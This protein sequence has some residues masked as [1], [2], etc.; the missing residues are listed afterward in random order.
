MNS[1]AWELWEGVARNALEEARATP[2]VSAFWLARAHGFEVRPWASA[3][4]R[5]DERE[6]VIYVTPRARPQRRHGLVAHELG[7]HLLRLEHRLEDSEDGARYLTGALLLPREPFG[8]D[9]TRTAWSLHRLRA[10]H[11]NASA[12]AIVARIVQVRDA[13]ATVIDR[14]RVTMRVASPWLEDPRLRRVSRWE[15]ELATRALEQREEVRGDELCY[16]VP[17]VDGAHQRVVVVCE[18]EQLSLRL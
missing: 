11:V 13:V 9:L 15:R 12:Q 3:G 8:R 10:I 18:L 1:T 17:L 7:H 14:G 4:A 5:L 2:P 16:A 6:G